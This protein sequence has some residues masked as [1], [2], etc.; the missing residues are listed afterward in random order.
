[1]QPNKNNSIM[2][3]KSIL[4]CFA[5]IAISCSKEKNYIITA[6]IDGVEDGRKVFL[7]VVDENKLSAIDTTTVTNNTFTFTGNIEATDVYFISV[8]EIRNNFPFILENDDITLTM[9]KDSI[10][11]SI[12]EGT[13]ENDLLQEYT[14]KANEIGKEIGALR[15]EN[16]EAQKARD[17]AWMNS[18]KGEY[19]SLVGKGAEFDTQFI[20]D[21]NESLMGLLILER[22]VRGKD[23]NVN[24]LKELFDSFPENLKQC[25]SGKNIS[26]ALNA[27]LATAIGSVAPAFSAPT[28]NGDLL[29]LSDVKGKVVIIDFWAAWCGPCRRENPNVVNVYNKYHDKGLEIIS[30]SLD[31]TPKQQDPKALWLKAIEDDKLTWHNVSNLQYFQD[32]IAKAYNINSIP[33]TFILD[34]EGKIIAK[35]L[36]GQA[37][38]DKMA[39]LLN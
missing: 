38:D 14:K 5:I 30:V 25:R 20:K 9:Y 24:E 31:G 7:N 16:A 4:V 39:E 29:A 19:E 34:A 36:R 23:I 15:S 27:K 37:L 22:K 1:L 12:I 28:P 6:S 35:N 2:L 11:A 13:K 3:K 21:N 10:N 33:A 26:E 18:L 8:D 17:T 32:P